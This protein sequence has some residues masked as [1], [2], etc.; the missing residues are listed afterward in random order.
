MTGNIKAHSFFKTINW[1]LL[2][3][4]AVEPPFKPK[5]VCDPTQVGAT[6]SM[7]PPAAFWGGHLLLCPASLSHHLCAF[8]LSPLQQ[9]C[10]PDLPGTFIH[11]LYSCILIISL[12]T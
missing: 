2:E 11:N 8:S 7:L 9:T 6:H 10:F 5:V 12:L 4:R 3:K 1:T